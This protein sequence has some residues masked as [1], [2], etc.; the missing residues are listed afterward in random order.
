MP[1]ISQGVAQ[2]ESTLPPV[3]VTREKL[4]DYMSRADISREQF[5]EMTGYS[6]TSISLFQAGKYGKDSKRTDVFLRRSIEEMMARHPLGLSVDEIQGKLYETENVTDLRHWFEQC[7]RRRALA[8]CYGPPGSQKTYVLKHLVCEFNRRELSRTDAANRAYYIYVSVN[9]RPRDLLAKLCREAGA[10]V[11]S[12]I[13]RCMSG[14]RQR[15]DNTQT[16][17]VLDEAQHLTIDCLEA[18]RE[19][20]D[21]APRIGALL[22]GSHELKKLFDR[23]AAELEQWNSRLKAGIELTGVSEQRAKEILRAEMPEISERNVAIAI[24]GARAPD[25]YSHSHPTYLNV[26]RLFNSLEAYRE[27]RARREE[28]A[29]A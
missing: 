15:L 29:D 25:A 14:L 7:H 12:S 6:V 28:K 20:H 5:A 26:R 1:D 4:R 22:A 18:V 19:M 23:R 3:E 24:A 13:Q 8:F 11:G 27:A 17:Y 9:M 10:V 21:E 2:I 16:L